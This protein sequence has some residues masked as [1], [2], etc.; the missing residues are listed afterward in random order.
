MPCKRQTWRF[1]FR[2]KLFSYAQLVEK[3]EE[4]DRMKRR[5]RAQPPISFQNGGN[6]DVREYVALLESFAVDMAH[7]VRQLFLKAVELTSLHAGEDIDE[8]DE[9]ETTSHW[10]QPVDNLDEQM[11]KALVLSRQENVALKQELQILKAQ[12]MARNDMDRMLEEVEPQRG[13]IKAKQTALR[14]ETLQKQIEAANAEIMAQSLEVLRL[15]QHIQY[16]EEELVRARKESTARLM[17]SPI[18]RPTEKSSPQSASPNTSKEATEMPEP[19][20]QLEGELN[21]EEDIHSAGKDN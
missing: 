3:E 6:Q 21:E 20:D 13:D 19:E 5:F 18:Q 11:W 9:Q 2:K 12:M 17:H 7:K 14:M 16:L 15:Q 4:L 10:N 8:D 1:T